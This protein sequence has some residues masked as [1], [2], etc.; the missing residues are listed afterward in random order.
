M[1]FAST[2]NRKGGKRT[3]RAKRQGP[4]RNL[5]LSHAPGRWGRA[6]RPAATE[7]PFLKLGSSS[8]TEML[9]SVRQF[10]TLF[11]IWALWCSETCAFNIPAIGLLSKTNLRLP[12]ASL[13][14][15]S[16]RGLNMQSSDSVGDRFKDDAKTTVVSDYIHHF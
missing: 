6:R 8:N 15:T 11:A 16:I 3:P 12:A 2:Y 14:R 10:A 13:K 4:T 5:S 7:P 1:K 9:I